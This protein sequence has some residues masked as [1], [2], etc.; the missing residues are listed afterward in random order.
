[1]HYMIEL[2][3]DC[4]KI[5]V[6]TLLDEIADFRF[7]NIFIVNVKKFMD[8]NKDYTLMSECEIKNFFEL[9]EIAKNRLILNLLK[10]YP[11]LV[12]KFINDDFI[13]VEYQKKGE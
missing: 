5:G 3:K 4:L 7:K 9:N 1:M 6:D 11:E 8:I 13:F 10:E 2:S 12:I